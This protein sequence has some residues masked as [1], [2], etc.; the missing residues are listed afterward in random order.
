MS[1]SKDEIAALAALPGFEDYGSSPPVLTLTSV[2]GTACDE[3]TV[4]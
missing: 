4:K 3:V 2:L 1:V